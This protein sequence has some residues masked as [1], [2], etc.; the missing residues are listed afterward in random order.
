M[1]R[2]SYIWIIFFTGLI[3]IG[4]TAKRKNLQNSSVGNKNKTT[5]STRTIASG[6]LIPDS[7]NAD[8]LHLSLGDSLTTDSL[9]TSELPKDS[10]EKKKKKSPLDAKV[11]YHSNDS[12][13]FNM[14]SKIMYLYDTAQMNYKTIELKANYI[15]MDLNTKELHAR[16]STDST[17][18]TTSGKPLF[19]DNGQEFTATEIK[20]NFETRKGLIKEAITNQGE[21]YL[22]ALVA[23]KD[24]NDVIYVKN[25]KFTTCTDPH[26]HFYI[27]TNKGKV[28]KD[29]VVVTGPANLRIADVPTPLVVPFGYF[30]MQSNRTSGIVLPQYGELNKYGFFLRGLGYYFAISDRFDLTLTGD[31]YTSLS[32]GLRTD[33]NYKTRYKFSGSFGV[34]YSQFQYGDPK[35]EGDFTITP[36]FQVVW[37]HSQDPKSNPTINFSAEVRVQGGNYN[38]YNSNSLSGIV[39]NQFQ[40]NISFSKSFRR[41]PV[42]LSLNMAHSQNTQNHQVSVTLPQIFLNVTRFYPFRRKKQVGELRWYENIGMQYS[43]TFLNTVSFADSMLVQDPTGV[44]NRMNNGIKQNLSMSTSLKILKYFS[45][46]P[47]VSYTEKWHF[48]NLRKYY[49]PTTQMVENDTIKGFFTTR[50][51]LVS[52][53]FTTTIYS[54]FRFKGN[55]IKAIRYVM[56]PTI[57]ANFQPNLGDQVQGYFGANGEFTSYSPNQIGTFGASNGQLIGSVGF[58]IVNNIEMKVKSRKDTIT[59]EKKI[60]LIENLVM[61]MNY[62]FAK[63]SLNL[64]PLTVAGRTNLLNMFALNYS[65]TFDPYAFRYGSDGI[66]R[67]INKLQVTDNGLP[68]R[69][70]NAYVKL[71]FNI[72]GQSKRNNS[73]TNNMSEAE[74]LIANNPSS[75]GYVDFNIPYSF[76]ASYIFNYS[77]PFDQEKISQSLAFSG[78]FNIT[79]KWKFSAQLYYDIQQNKITQSAFT[80]YRDLHCWEMSFQVIPFGV[81]QSYNFSIYVKSPLLQMLKLQRQSGLT[82]VY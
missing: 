38:Q 23:K 40:S 14:D 77:K 80:I 16:G 35:I 75:Y 47:Q 51:L 49:D 17:T 69:M 1:H 74:Q 55:G 39:S 6:K 11:D 28:I 67:Q 52:A 76:T 7:L 3:T 10:T 79:R 46:N 56:A 71:D 53:N 32:F 29:K 31:I 61:S 36:S 34:G 72:K 73:V 44:L 33:M 19:S 27:Q 5:D 9:E 18:G 60:P 62:N 57:N 41:T 54:M 8:S 65:F 50:D 81:R 13:V 48:S 25:A 22:H 12:I 43:L 66:A 30:P 82:G 59:G 42:S 58:S 63:D 78:D 70:T 21:T 15:A 37:K 24:S 26:P 68:M 45:L 64:S 20:Y 4:C 2:F